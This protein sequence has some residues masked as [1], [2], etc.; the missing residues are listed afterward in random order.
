MPR[1]LVTGGCGFIG[2]HLTAALLARGSAVM[3]LD[4][5][6]SGSIERLPKA[7]ELVIADIRD[8]GAVSD[9]MAGCDACFHLAAIASV[10]RC[11]EEWARSHSVNLGG[12]VRV[13]EAAR[14]HGN[15][16]VVY[17][18]SA[19]IYG[20]LGPIPLDETA[21][22]HPISA[23]GSDKR[24]CELHA[25]CGGITFGLPTVGLR[26]FNV[27]GPGQDPQ[28]P[29][30][31]AVSR[32]AERLSQGRGID[33]FGDG[34]QRRDFIYV[35]DVVRALMLALPAASPAAPIF[36]VCTGSSVS[37]LDLATTLFKLQGK[38]PALKFQAARPG[39]I[40]YSLGDARAAAETLGFHAETS[41]SAGLAATLQSVNS[42]QG[43]QLAGASAVHVTAAF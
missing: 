28:S 31:G 27:Y 17:A 23:Y 13:F 35:G 12:T 2:A 14:K 26:F 10:Q 19:A 20:D 8:D 6:S 29:Y 40:R 38:T 30:S 1:Y 21:A 41:L 4:D 37:V 39:E 34:Q 36:N 32:F 11:Q 5:L 7:A 24:G 3:V 22:A 15:L 42:R 18:S 33:I 16:P 25:R 9:A 43:P